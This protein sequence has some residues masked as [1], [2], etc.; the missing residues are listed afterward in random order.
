[1]CSGNANKFSDFGILISFV[2]AAS[3][4]F[5]ENTLRERLFTRQLNGRFV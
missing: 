2:A 1:M 5:D 3:A 4:I